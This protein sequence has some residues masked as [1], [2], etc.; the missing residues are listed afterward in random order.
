MGAL[1]ARPRYWLEE[2][3]KI[4]RQKDSTTPEMYQ[5]KRA[6]SKPFDV[7]GFAAIYRPLL[8]RRVKD[9]ERTGKEG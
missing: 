7:A 5:G 8:T 6:G 1:T 4:R 9:M 2:R 3:K